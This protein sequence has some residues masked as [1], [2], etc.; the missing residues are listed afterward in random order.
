MV[1]LS[2]WLGMGKST[3]GYRGLGIF[4]SFFSTPNQIICNRPSAGLSQPWLAELTFWKLAAGEQGA[5]SPVS[6][7]RETLP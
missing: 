3:K 2:I 7:S 4:K 6:G 5:G 1:C